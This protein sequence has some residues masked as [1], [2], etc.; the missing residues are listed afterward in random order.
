[1]NIKCRFMAFTTMILLSLSISSCA[2]EQ[3]SQVV[4]QPFSN[5]KLD[6]LV[7]EV[8]N[9][10][11]MEERV[12]QLHGIRPSL[13][14]VDGRLSKELC[15][16]L[17]PHGVGHISQFACMQDFTPDELRDFVRD[18][19]EYVISHN[20]AGIPAIFHEEAI[21]GFST[22]G[23]T[24]YP[25]QIG[26]AC[27][28]NPDLVELKS[29]YTAESMRS[30][31]AQMAL[32]PMVDVIRTQHFNRGEE[33]YGEDSYLSSAMAVA[34][35]NGLQGDDL[36]TGVAATTKHFLG[37]GGG[38]SLLKKEIMEEIMTPHEVG[39]RIAGSKS[40]MPGYHSFEGETA[41]TNSYFLQDLLR[42]YLQ[43][44]GIVVS[45]YFA[46]GV[47]GKAKGNPLHFYERA[48]KAINAGA[49]LELCDPEAFPLLPELIAQGK[50]SEERFEEAVKQNLR[51][52]GRLGL[53]DKKP[54]LYDEG[55]INLN[56]AEY[57]KLAYDLA[58]Q[59]VVLLKNDGT[60][61]L[62]T[63]SKKIALVGPNANS[64]WAMLGDYTY[65]ALHAFFQSAEVDNDYHKIYTLKEG[66]ERVKGDN[67]TLSY[68]RGCDWDASIKSAVD[69]GGDN[70]VELSKLDKLINMLRRDADPTNLNRA[71]Q[72]CRKS[73]VIVAAV[74][75]NAALCGE[76]RARKGIRLPGDQ[77]AFVE[78]LIDTGKPVVVVI[79]GGRAQVLSEK[80]LSGAA[81]IIQ[82]WY[83]GQ[84]GGNAVA[85]ILFGEVNPSGK[86]CT[87]YPAT[88]SRTPLCY[89][90]GDRR[91][92][93][94]VQF[95]FGYG[96]SYTTF[97]YT[98]LDSTLEATI[99]ED[100]VEVSFTISNVGKRDGTEVAQLYISPAN[101]TGSGLKSIQ[102]K[103]F[104]RV[105]VA[106]GESR[107]VTFSFDPE[108][109][110]LYNNQ[111]EENPWRVVPG[112]YK[113]K[114]GSSSSD[115]HL[116]APLTL[117]GERI[118]MER[119]EVF[120]SSSSVK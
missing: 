75:E 90:Y 60:L 86:L 85:D 109:I 17:I 44:D 53:L 10:L 100:R 8:Y 11:S 36:S 29:R 102:L 31:G 52:K 94:L 58:T 57:D 64:Y 68:E 112:E 115:I 24:T 87:S 73:D 49:D 6:A 69:E 43:F 47:K 63:D 28:W 107:R 72:I 71:M 15:D 103:G 99:G 56:K 77:E 105:E 39:I 27:S 67:V 51:M 21:T 93:G 79:F 55:E 61:P 110:S 89:N 4:D 83:P 74:G 48:E 78:S 20:A 114:I 14:T 116:V 113:I 92:K 35:I 65:Q 97:E 5:P 120:F 62:T 80:I 32:S 3:R 82:A 30:V 45:D 111:V 9:S 46:I 40:L 91:M 41:I 18:L 81:A 66:M 108:L 25:Q 19:Q 13:I 96:L 33:S 117:V 54:K 98:N 50:V 38:S 16:Q 70:R 26:V 84:Q 101:V 34:F 2:E 37:Y 106:A 22:K 76:G 95:P 42:D 119:R 1:M 7:D 12:A 118:K 104:E 23:A 59:S 88:E